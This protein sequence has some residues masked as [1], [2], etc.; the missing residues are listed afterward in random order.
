MWQALV[1]L[2]AVEVVYS[3][4]E[5]F[6]KPTRVVMTDSGA[7]S[8]C[9]E[10]VAPIIRVGSGLLAGVRLPVGDKHVDAYLGIPYAQPPVGELRFQKPRPISPWKGVHNATTKPKA[11]KQLPCPLIP[12]MTLDYTNSSEDC[13][14]INVWKPTSVCAE[15]HATCKQKIPVFVFIHGGGFQWGDSALLIYDPANFV[16]LTDVIV[17][18]FNYR[19]GID[20]FLS[21]EIPEI[22]GNMG[23]W[24]QNMVLKWVRGNIASFGGDPNDVTLGGQSAGSTSVGLHVVSPHSKGL[25][26]RAIMQSGS[27]LSMVATIYFR[28]EGK[29]ISAAGALGCYD[30]KKVL[31]EQLKDVIACLRR[32]DSSFILNAVSKFDFV[33]R[34]FVPIDKDDFLP[35]SILTPQS[36]T[37]MGIGE[38]LLGTTL[39]EATMFLSVLQDAFHELL[40]M[41]KSQYRMVC[42]IIMAQTLNLPVSKS[43]E[44]VRAYFGPDDKEHSFEEVQDTLSKMLGDAVF[45]CPVQLFADSASKRGV[46]TYRY[47]FGHRPAYSFYDEWMGVTHGEE[48]FYTMGSLPFINDQSRFT[49]AMGKDIRDLMVSKKYTTKDEA[50]MKEIVDCLGFV[51]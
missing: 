4:E 32:L 14:Y 18:T 26:K 3:N 20:G 42:I 36:W 23:L 41:L 50:F 16:A 1:F 10:N 11:C 49:D 39:N 15:P 44:I 45:D 19:V 43:K 37:D 27:P 25:F 33:Q 24:D 9:S 22:P 21:L 7:V 17:V 5:S 6:A 13:L 12:K 48:L 46:K 29:F 28:G 47:L 38:L 35:H 34:M 31:K 40:G 51:H 8:V 30:P 2:L